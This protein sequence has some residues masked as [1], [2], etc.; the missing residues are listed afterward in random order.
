MDVLDRQRFA[1]WNLGS[2]C[3]KGTL[4][5]LGGLDGHSSVKWCKFARALWDLSILVSS[6]VMWFCNST[7]AFADDAAKVGWGG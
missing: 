2:Q 3:G 7:C 5:P 1:Y 4:E 6:L